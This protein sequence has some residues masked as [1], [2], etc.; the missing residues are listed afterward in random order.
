[1]SSLNTANNVTPYHDALENTN[2]ISRPLHTFMKR[3][4]C[5]ASAVKDLVNL[6]EEYKEER[7]LLC[8][9]SEEPLASH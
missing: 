3:P 5:L 6:T 8:L 1:M 7:S 4:S 2:Q 9:P